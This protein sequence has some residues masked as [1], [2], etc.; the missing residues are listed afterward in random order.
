MEI[1]DSFCGIGPWRDRDRLLP[2]EPEEILK[3]MDYFGIAKAVVYG[4]SCVGR[5]MA[6]DGNAALLERAAIS[7]RFLP[8]VTLAPSPCGPPLTADDYA[9]TMRNAGARTAW[10]MPQPGAQNHGVWRWLIGELLHMC[11]QTKTPLLLDVEALTPDDVH[12]V[13]RDFPALRLILT[14][15]GY[16]S[17]TWLHPLLRMHPELRVCTGHFYIPP[18]GPMLFLRHFGVERLIFGSGLPNFSPGG[19]IGHVM[20]ATI[21][22]ADKEKILGGNM[23]ALMAEVEL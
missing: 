2:Y 19:L 6:P 13:C 22:D 3:L 12:N 1:I 11:S 4:S 7:D 9:E 21:P 5:A 16:G 17:D 20:Y 14:G 8:A 15:V 18:D 23:K 10:L